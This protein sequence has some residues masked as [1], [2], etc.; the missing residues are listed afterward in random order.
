MKSFIKFIIDFGPLVVFFVF[1]KKTGS[2][3][4]AIIPL[5]IATLISILVSY[6]LEKK[7]PIMPTVGGIIILIFGGLSWYFKDPIFIKMKPTII[8]I[9]F[10]LA[11]FVGNYFNKPLFKYL[12][13]ESIKLEDQGW[14]ELGKRWAYFFIFLAFLN[15]VIWR[16]FSEDLW[17]NF[18]VFGIL[19][20]TFIFSISQFSIIKKF[21]K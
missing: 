6:L 8:N 11:I 2:L 19:F 3:I 16:N 21:Q 13:G 7:I 20:L 10:A 5:M 12:L 9:I 18:K 4:E 17:V 15:E 1:Y 14:I